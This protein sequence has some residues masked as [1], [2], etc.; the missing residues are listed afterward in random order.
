LRSRVGYRI[1]YGE[2]ARLAE[3]ACFDH[4]W[5]LDLAHWIAAERGWILDPGQER[6]FRLIG[7]SQRDWGLRRNVARARGV[8]APPA[9]PSTLRNEALRYVIAA[10][11]HEVTRVRHVT[12]SHL[13]SDHRADARA[14]AS[15]EAASRIRDTAT[16]RRLIGDAPARHARAGDRRRHPGRD[17]RG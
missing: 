16:P 17:A 7:Y 1:A 6:R 2:A 12:G 5:G 10:D 8:H 14:D 13:R 3:M 11:V 15:P 9:A 4:G